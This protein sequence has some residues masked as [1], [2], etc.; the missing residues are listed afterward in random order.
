MRA[1]KNTDS[2]QIQN[3]RK[4]K[5]LSQKHAL[6]KMHKDF[7]MS[8]TKNST[9]IGGIKQNKTD[10]GQ[11]KKIEIKNGIKIHITK[12]TGHNWT[13]Y[14]EDC[15]LIYGKKLVAVFDGV[16]GPCDGSGGI[17]SRKAAEKLRKIASR[18]NSKNYKKL[19][20]AWNKECTR[21]STTALILLQFKN[22][23]ILL[24][25]GDSIAFLKGKQINERHGQGNIVTRVLGDEQPFD[26]YELPEG[27]IKLCTDGIY[28]AGDDITEVTINDAS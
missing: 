14:S 20:D 17:A 5:R 7:L 15:V 13:R 9:I 11:E 10:D 3:S 16:S 4:I 8:K 6:V 23:R 12:G 19:I 18:I 24:N 26:E 2:K 21:Q 25:K 1:K 28:D 22:K 27:E